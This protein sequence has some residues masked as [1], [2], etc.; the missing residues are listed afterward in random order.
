MEELC[1]YLF[2][3]DIGHVVKHG[4]VKHGQVKHG[5]SPCFSSVCFTFPFLLVQSSPAH[6]LQHALKLSN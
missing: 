4:L 1:K 3:P 6:V 2:M 5:T